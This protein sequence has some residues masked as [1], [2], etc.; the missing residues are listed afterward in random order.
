M[1]P[2]IRNICTLV[3]SL[4]LAAPAFSSPAFVLRSGTGETL[5]EDS[6]AGKIVLCFYE[7][8]DTTDVNRKLKDSLMA[9]INASE[10][11]VPFVLAV[12][13]CSG[14]TWP[15]SAFYKKALREQSKKIGYTLWGD[16]TGKMREDFGFAVDDANFPLIDPDGRVLYSARG[17]VSD[18]GIEEIV[19][20]VTGLM[21]EVQ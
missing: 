6:I 1:N 21:E 14:A 5:T 12:A 13:D 9:A 19:S 3:I 20:L 15:I 18:S 8:R 10:V 17:R 7:S 2:F 4:I 16:W 11:N